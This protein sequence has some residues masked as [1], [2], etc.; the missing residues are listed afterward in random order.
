L[1]IEKIFIY[2][3]PNIVS[4]F[5]SARIIVSDNKNDLSKLSVEQQ[6]KAEEIFN[7][8]VD[9][10]KEYEKSPSFSELKSLNEI[11][12]EVIIFIQKINNHP[13]KYINGINKIDKTAYEI[14]FDISKNNNLDKI[15]DASLC[16]VNEILELEKKDTFTS[17]YSTL[18]KFCRFGLKNLF[19]YDKSLSAMHSNIPF[20][21]ES[22]S[23]LYIG[24]GRYTKLIA[25]GYLSKTSI[26]G[27]NIAGGK[28][29]SSHIFT[30][31]ALPAPKQIFSRNVEDCVSSAIEIGFPVVVKPRSGN[32]GRAVSVDLKDEI[33]V[34]EAFY[35][36]KKEMGSSS[37][38][39][40]KFVLGDDHRIL[41]VNYNVV[42]VVKRIPAHIVSD[43]IHSIEQ[44]IEITNK[45]ERRDGLKLFPIKIDHEILR[46]L[47]ENKLKL[48]DVPIKGQYIKLR[49]VSNQS[50]GG[51]TLD[52][53]DDIHPDNI[54]MAIDCAKVSMLDVVGVDF[55]TTDINKSWKDG[56]GGI[57]EI[58]AGP[59]VDLH[60]LPSKGFSRNI[61]WEMTRAEFKSNDISSIP[62]ITV[63]GKKNRTTIAKK[64]TSYLS[65]LGFSIGLF[66]NNKVYING[67]FNKDFSLDLKDMLINRNINCAVIEVSSHNLLKNGLSYYKSDVSILTDD[68][69]SNN[70]KDISFC[71]NIEE[72]I[73]LL[74]TKITSNLFIINY[75]S[76]YKEL[77]L[78][79]FPLNK[80][81]IIFSSLDYKKEKLEEYTK[82]KINCLYLERKKEKL[83]LI[84]ICKDFKKVLKVV[85][86]DEFN[87][88]FIDE[89]YSIAVFTYF[90]KNVNKAKENL[91]LLESPNLHDSSFAQKYM[92]NNLYTTLNFD[93]KKGIDFILKQ[94]KNFHKCI[95]LIENKHFG[96]IISDKL[97]LDN[98]IYKIDSYNNLF[99]MWKSSL[100]SN[101]KKYHFVFFSEILNFRNNFIDSLEENSLK[102]SENKKLFSIE[103][104]N[105]VF[106]SNLCIKELDIECLS[107]NYHQHGKRD[108]VIISEEYNV[109]KL[110][111]IERLIISAFN[112][113]AK[114]VIAPIFPCKL[115]KFYDIFISDSIS[116]GLKKLAIQKQQNSNI[117]IKDEIFLLDEKTL[118]EIINT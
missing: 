78:K 96:K 67:D 74:Q 7:L 56:Y 27:K 64:T 98:I 10:E 2:N 11:F 43:G 52:L 95:L 4:L 83:N 44:L 39:V 28:D 18:Y 40:E 38:V 118:I 16:F 26:L 92:N 69:I 53:T 59:G 17:K 81:C 29:K 102:I 61:S 1:K 116:L 79:S 88:D 111:D 86:I 42:G 112:Q 49:G 107:L 60:M 6:E 85:S 65:C 89:M 68:F 32:K 84:Y 36:V 51:T 93:D 62:I 55:V 94:N 50:L 19:N 24:N 115:E 31:S 76:I 34:R 37:V 100:L 57:V 45:S 23:R 47:E 33:S 108:L 41:V 75:S 106:A 63:L 48:T 97:D 46:I 117:Y 20:Q 13:V 82:E 114:G 66:S 12:L 58:N 113:G 71:N 22:G 73:L 105:N 70:L 3:G 25:A 110:E 9:Y 15:I 35:L 54:Q 101:I 5:S 104:I 109:S 77:I 14:Y 91:S 99:S 72:K 21:F 90:S 30:R 103:N 80:I 87:N 8:A